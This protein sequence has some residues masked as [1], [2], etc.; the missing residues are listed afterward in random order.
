MTNYLKSMRSQVETGAWAL[1]NWSRAP[2]CQPELPKFIIIGGQKCGSTFLH[3]YLLA[4][5][6]ISM[7]TTLRRNSR[8]TL[9]VQREMHYF[10]DEDTYQKGHDW[11]K[12][13]FQVRRSHSDE[14]NPGQPYTWGERTPNYLC[15]QEAPARIQAVMPDTKFLVLLR[16]PIKRAYSHYQMKVRREKNSRDFDTAIGEVLDGYSQEHCQHLLKGVSPFPDEIGAEHDP[17]AR[18]LY[19]FQLARWFRHFPRQQFLVL[20]SEAM[21]SNPSAA[22]SEAYE[23]LGVDDMRLDRFVN[24]KARSYPPMSVETRQ[25]LSRFYEP[26]NLALYELLGVDYGWH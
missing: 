13:H 14:R 4:H 26:F 10:S 3:D 21:F 9:K 23:F 22:L 24:R 7:A 6:R 5:P 20:Q 15:K 12:K 16:N 2:F 19:A 18:G 1:Q 17:I 8:G 25:R 11:Y